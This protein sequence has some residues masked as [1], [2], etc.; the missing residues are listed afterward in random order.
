MVISA[1]SLPASLALSA[2]KRN[3]HLIPLFSLLLI[4]AVSLL[5]RL[6][7]FPSIWFDEGYKLNAAYTMVITG[8]YATYTVDGFIPFD[9]GTSG[10]PADILPTAL[11]IKVLGVGVTAARLVSVVYTLAACAAVYALAL[12][13]WDMPTAF[14][15]VV[16]LLVFP[17]QGNMSFILMGRQTLSE[18]AAFSLMV[19][20]L[21]LVFWGWE[22][23]AWSQ[24]GLGGVVIGLGMLSKTQFAISLLPALFMVSVVMVWKR[25]GWRLYLAPLVSIMVVMGGWMLLG[26]ILTPAAIRAQNSALL[27]DAIRSNLL[28]PLMGSN[29]G[30]TGYLLIG[31]MTLAVIT[32]GWRLFLAYRRVG[33]RAVWAAEAVLTVFVC[34]TLV[35]YA[36]LSVGWPRYAFAGVMVALI[37]LGRW[38]WLVVGERLQPVS[39]NISF[40]G[41]ALAALVVNLS[42][43]FSATP[44]YDAQHTAAYI[45]EYIDAEA[46]IE[47]WEWELDM[48]SK[49][50]H[51][52]HP[53]QALLFEAIR[54]AS[55]GEA[56][57]LAYDVLKAEPDYLIE[58]PF[59]MWTGIYPQADLEAYFV[60]ESRFGS[61]TIW[62]RAG[63]AG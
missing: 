9:P 48:L 56:F 11:A 51:F 14:V 5:L 10:G 57:A 30:S 25:Q 33:V 63:A 54:Q 31:I 47:T 34:F 8:Q 27:M 16:V 18:A 20:G 21:L 50:I 62:K 1:R 7:T 15:S 6:E 29:L 60:E 3:P 4:A 59:S 44:A 61:Y 36:L 28:T 19:I 38:L 22:R 2:H 55:R 40:A 13:L 52:H 17:A 58:G 24:A 35:W 26:N 46:V 12:R 39:R 53:E 32:T 37:L 41:L 23:Q 45:A 42:L 43:I 49:H